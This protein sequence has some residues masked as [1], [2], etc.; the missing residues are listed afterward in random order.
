MGNMGRGT[1]RLIALLAIGLVVA[2]IYYVQRRNA[3]PTSP[4]Q[5]VVYVNPNVSAPATPRP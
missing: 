1:P 5:G 3:P 2:A 4:D